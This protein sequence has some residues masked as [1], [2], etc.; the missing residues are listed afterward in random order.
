M[1]LNL[2]CVPTPE[3]RI[4]YIFPRTSETAQNY[5]EHKIQA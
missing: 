3:A 2:D 1:T 5:I 4:V